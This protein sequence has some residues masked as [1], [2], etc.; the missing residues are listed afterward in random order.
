MTFAA[1][2]SGTESAYKLRDLPPESATQPIPITTVA[3]LLESLDSHRPKDLQVLRSIC[4]ILC[5]FLNEDPEHLTMQAVFDAKDE[6]RSYLS[7]RPYA[8]NSIRTYVNNVKTLLK[9]AARQGWR[10]SDDVPS[11]WRPVMK[12]ASER[13]RRKLIK[14]LCKTQPNPQDV[15]QED[16]NAWADHAVCTGTSVNHAN[17]VKTWFWRTLHDLDL[18]GPQGKQ[19]MTRY[20]IGLDKFPVRL[21]N[22]VNDLLKWKQ[23]SFSANRPKNGRHR[24]VTARNLRYVLCGL[25][26]YAANIRGEDAISSLRELVREDLVTSFVEWSLNERKVAGL[27]ARTNLGMLRAALRHHPMHRS[28]DLKWLGGLLA[29]IPIEPDSERK[30]RKAFKYL[31]YS[32]LEEIPKRI[33]AERKRAKRPMLVSRL[34]MCELLMR[35]LITLPW[36]QLNVR[37]CRVSGATPNV[38][39]ERIPQFSDITRPEWV[40]EEERRD[41]N[42]QFW[43]FQFNVQETKTGIE[44]HSLM[45]KQLVAL[46]EEYLSSHRARLLRGKNTETLFVNR[47]GRPLSRGSMT[48]LV[49]ELTLRYGGKKVNPHTFRDIV[50]YTWLL[51]HPKDYLTLSKMLWHSKLATTLEIY[52]GRFNESAGVVAMEA[53]LEEREAGSS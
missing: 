32:V 29:S 27:G 46:L 48:E 47:A 2:H 35:W 36:R 52:G 38:M 44:V 28:I 23:A 4:S 24:A 51:H 21:R 40:I 7:T 10:P 9:E 13:K 43:Q 26:G 31:E 20:M 45:P 1:L 12:K 18:I 11:P 25:Y 50:A 3:D 49:E 30:K 33:Q 17:Q 14:T 22:E 19:F 6:F 34:V 37:G 15:S 41:P 5:T 42:A 8:E 16:V 53:W 39:K